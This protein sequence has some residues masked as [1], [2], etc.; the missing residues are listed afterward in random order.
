MNKKFIVYLHALLRVKLWDRIW[1]SMVK[2]L[3]TEKHSIELPPYDFKQLCYEIRPGDIILVEGRSRVAEVIKLITQSPWTHSALYI[4]HLYDIKDHLLREQVEHYYLD[5]SEEPLI[6]EA[7]LGEGAVVHSLKKYNH[8]HLRICRPSNITPKDA[9]KVIEYGIKKLG[10]EYHVRQ[11]F[12][13][14][15]F[16]IP[17]SLLP[18]RWRSSLFMHNTGPATQTVCSSM[19]SEA[20][21]QI[22]FPIL[23]VTEK[24]QNGEYN[25]YMRNPRLV[26][27]KDFDYSPYFEIIKYPIYGFD[28]IAMYKKLPWNEEVIMCHEPGNCY[29]PEEVMAKKIE[30]QRPHKINLLRKFKIKP[31][32]KIQ[33]TTTSKQQTDKFNTWSHSLINIIAKNN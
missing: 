23:P 33:H 6:I 10:S 4:G 16:L 1:N 17:Y 14:A 21:Q 18:R 12:D 8:D 2:W 25:L 28:R 22:K 15:R 5:G 29:L 32:E 30:P 3:N 26:T 11:L 13:L 31:S 9:Q 20:F 27:P 7:L 24:L 19:I